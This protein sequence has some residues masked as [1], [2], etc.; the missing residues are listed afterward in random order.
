MS[1][2]NDQPISFRYIFDTE[3]EKPF[4]F[5]ILLDARTLT[6]QSKVCAEEHS[7]TDLDYHRCD[8]CRLADLGISK[9]PVAVNLQDIVQCFSASISYD[10]VN[11]TIETDDRSYSKQNVT[12]QSGLSSILGLI[13]TTSGCPSLDYL[14]PMV[15]THLPFA[16]ISETVYRAISMYL[17][18]QFTRAKNG[19]EPD[20]GLGGLT[21]IYSQIDKINRAMVQRL[22]SATQQDA[23]LNAVVIL[24]SFAKMVPLTISGMINDL[25]ELFWPYLD[26]TEPDASN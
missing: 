2:Q 21:D 19:L 4:V 7:W 13:M 18:A 26:Q 20:W 8:G 1:E 15:K 24:D 17:L 9:C 22:Q 6:Y 11:I 12:M 5:E 16:S 25:D 3:L 23:S 14:R 10:K